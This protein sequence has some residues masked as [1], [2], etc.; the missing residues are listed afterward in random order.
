MHNHKETNQGN[1]ETKLF[2]LISRKSTGCFC[3]S[4]DCF[5]Q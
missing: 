3:D 2:K 1:N 5:Y 4:T